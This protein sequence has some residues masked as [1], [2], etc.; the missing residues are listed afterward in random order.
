MVENKTGRRWCKVS[1]SCSSHW[2][3]F[4]YL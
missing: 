4:N 1:I 2:L 3:I